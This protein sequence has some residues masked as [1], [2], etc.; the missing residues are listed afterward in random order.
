MFFIYI[1]KHKTE[2]NKTKM[3]T[4][5]TSLFRRGSSDAELLRRLV[6]A[7]SVHE[8]LLRTAVFCGNKRT[9][10]LIAQNAQAEV[11]LLGWHRGQTAPLDDTC[12]FHVLMG[13]VRETNATGAT[14]DYAS[15]D[16]RDILCAQ[17]SMAG[18]GANNVT[19]HVYR[20]S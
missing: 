20:K 9:R 19:V 4:F 3:N 8:Q 5:L 15:G 6:A 14:T 7:P 11:W 13:C 12:A 18:I 16:G 1:K 10:T 17:H 2:K